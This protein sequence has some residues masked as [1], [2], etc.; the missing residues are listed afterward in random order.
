MLAAAVAAVLG[1]T[2]VAVI[3]LTRD[4]EPAMEVGSWQLSRSE[5]RGNLEAVEDNAVYR[6]LRDQ[7]GSPITVREEDGGAFT[8]EF[9]AEVLNERLTFR[10]AEVALD[11]RGGEVTDEDRAM[12]RSVLG[13]KL[14]STATLGGGRDATIA[15]VMDGFGDYEATLEDGL[16]TIEALKRDLGEEVPPVEEATGPD[17]ATGGALEDGPS[18]AGAGS[19][20]APEDGSEAPVGAVDDEG[21]VLEDGASPDDEQADDGSLLEGDQP[22]DGEGVDDSADPV[23]E[24]AQEIEALLR[25]TLVEVAAGE[26]V[27]VAPDLGEFSPATATIS[28][29]A[30]DADLEPLD[31]SDQT[32]DPGALPGDSPTGEVDVAPG[33]L[34]ADTD[35]TDP[36]A[37]GGTPGDEGAGDM[38]TVD[39]GPDGDT[40]VE[41]AVT[42]P[43]VA[44]SGAD[45][46]AGGG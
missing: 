27:T 30:T 4:E 28:P 41:G 45:A 39:E 16:A 12:A 17:D 43:T 40:A 26:G 18:D 33:E 9:V 36:G 5:L 25:E 15:K 35:P 24:R 1:I 8:T 3:Q 7:V 42:G 31:P 20:G 6:T 29:A 37:T 14:V 22:L 44:P 10:L 38:G 21:G 46:P 11:E 23:E 32:V 19:D 34:P 13:G 2:A